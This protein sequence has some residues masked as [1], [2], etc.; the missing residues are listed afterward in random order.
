MKKQ[1]KKPSYY[2]KVAIFA[3]GQMAFSAYGFL[4][5]VSSENSV[6]LDGF[7]R[8]YHEQHSEAEYADTGIVQTLQGRLMHESRIDNTLIIDAHYVLAWDG[9][10]YKNSGQVP[11][12]LTL[13]NAQGLIERSGAFRISDVKG[14][15]NL[16]SEHRLTQNIDRLVAHKAFDWGDIHLGRQAITLGVSR[17][18]QQ[19]DVLYPVSFNNLQ[20]DYRQG[21][22]AVRFEVPMGMLSVLDMAWVQGET[23]NDSAGFVRFKANLALLEYEITAMQLH[24]DAMLT[25]SLQQSLHNTGLWQELSFIQDESKSN[26]TYHRFSIGFDNTVSDFLISAE[27]YYNE[28]GTDQSDQYLSKAVSFNLYT[29]NAISFLAQQY[30]FVGANYLE[31]SQDNFSINYAYNI[32]DNSQ[33][34]SAVFNHNI[35][36]TWDVNV[37]TNLPIS[38][39]SQAGDHKLSEFS[40]YFHSLSLNLSA[41]F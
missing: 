4:E 18:S 26:K 12:H 33:L 39:G 10:A 34:L 32:N 16:N 28:L 15:Y 9:V 36:A 25:I 11:D 27:Y 29:K 13:N 35:N 23:K 37:Q 30:L 8:V 41:I 22:D 24:E 3:F 19:S 21:V 14:N 5:N 17:F 40:Q 7:T 31:G 38:I 20:S 6:Q 2:S 1:D